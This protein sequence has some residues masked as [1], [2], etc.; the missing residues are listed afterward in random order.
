[1]LQVF[2]FE[3]K[4]VRFVGTAENP[5]WIGKDTCVALSIS[6]YRDAL[7][8]L[9]ED[10][11]VSVVVDTPGGKQKMIAVTESGL[12]Q[13]VLK[14]PAHIGKTFVRWITHEVLPSIRKTGSYRNNWV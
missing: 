12:Y 9:D 11:R 6:K 8:D 4:Q 14:A 1:M 7:A 3:Q 2:S 13:L 10:E 5:A